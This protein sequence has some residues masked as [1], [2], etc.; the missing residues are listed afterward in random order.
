MEPF[1]VLLALCAGNSTVTGEFSSQRPV[2]HSF[3]VSLIYAWINVWV[4]NREPGD[5]RRYRAHYDVT[6]MATPRHVGYLPNTTYFPSSQLHPHFGLVMKKIQPFASGPSFNWK[7]I[8]GLAENTRAI[9]HITYTA[10]PVY[11][12]HLMGY[13]SAFWGSSRWPR[14]T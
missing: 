9:S 2:T 4:N 14:A 10:K 11:N 7:Y 3:D 13:L 8:D 5:L 1:S 6:I 12:D